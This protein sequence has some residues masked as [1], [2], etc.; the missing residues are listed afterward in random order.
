MILQVP[1]RK[2]LLPLQAM[3]LGVGG[4]LLSACSAS[5]ESQNQLGAT[6]TSGIAGVTASASGAP[7]QPVV[8]APAPITT[9]SIRS[10]ASAASLSAPH[11]QTIRQRC[12][13]LRQDGDVWQRTRKLAVLNRGE[14]GARMADLHSPWNKENV[15]FY[16]AS[17]TGKPSKKPAIT[18]NSTRGNRLAASQWASKKWASARE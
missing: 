8:A 13:T 15:A 6:A 10:N 2:I 7:V 4:L 12:E 9:G 3:L 14:A 5:P 18:E 16:M 1:G 17:C 11:R